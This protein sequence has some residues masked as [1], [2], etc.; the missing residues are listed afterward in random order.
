MLYGRN[1]KCMK[2]FGV[3]LARPDL[4]WDN[5]IQTDEKGLRHGVNR[6]QLLQWPVTVVDVNTNA[7]FTDIT[8]AQIA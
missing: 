2:N 4:K 3:P 6:T 7:E 5:N 8:V 1:K